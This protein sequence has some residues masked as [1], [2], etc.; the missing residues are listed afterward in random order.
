VILRFCG[1][2][3]RLAAGAFL[4]GLGWL[5]W[6]LGIENAEHYVNK[7][8][9]TENWDNTPPATQNAW[10]FAGNTSPFAVSYPIW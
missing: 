9:F 4:G 7:A 10:F 1:L 5:R 8:V 3:D 6:C 2:G